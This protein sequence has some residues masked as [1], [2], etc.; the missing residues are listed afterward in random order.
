MSKINDVALMSRLI[1]NKSTQIDKLELKKMFI[2]VLASVPE[3][4]VEEKEKA[5]R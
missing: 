3:P 4:T 1:T 5:Y 2:I